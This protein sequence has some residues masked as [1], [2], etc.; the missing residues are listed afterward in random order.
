MHPNAENNTLTTKLI[1]PRQD[2]LPLKTIPLKDPMGELC[3]TEEAAMRHDKFL[4]CWGC[5]I[6]F[7]FSPGPPEFNPQRV[8]I[9]EPTHCYACRQQRKLTMSGQE[10]GQP[11]EQER[12]SRRTRDR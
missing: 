3:A 9:R 2:A 6:Y 10:R 5:G 12:S 4:T 1:F 8:R 11:D 7:V